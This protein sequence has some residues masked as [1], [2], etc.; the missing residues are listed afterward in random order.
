VGIRVGCCRKTGCVSVYPCGGDDDSRMDQILRILGAKTVLFQGF[1]L[2]NGMFRVLSGT[3]G[4]LNKFST[5]KI[6]AS[7]WR[8]QGYSCLE[9]SVVA[10]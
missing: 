10:C 1:K 5:T 2:Q 6:C 7:F 4:T 8:I 3:C 9:A